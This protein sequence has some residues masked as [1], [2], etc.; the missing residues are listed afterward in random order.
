MTDESNGTV[1]Y[2]I[3]ELLNKIDTRLDEMIK[4][5]HR[6]ADA[7]TV[8]QHAQRIEAIERSSNPEVGR[9]LVAEFR[10]AQ[11]QIELMRA[12]GVRRDILDEYQKGQNMSV[13]QNRK[14]II[15]LVIGNAAVVGGF[16][17]HFL[18]V[19]GF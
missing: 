8:E 16:V 12:A 6:K 1:K 2:T 7:N 10:I 18:K 13:A 4:E 17:L 14:Y 5:I 3:R 15:G 11:A 9:Q 19:P